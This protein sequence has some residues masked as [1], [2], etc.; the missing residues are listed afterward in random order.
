MRGLRPGKNT[1]AL[2]SLNNGNIQSNILGFFLLVLLC[3]I[4][5]RI[6]TISK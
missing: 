2:F 5:V 4:N 1:A 6:L 3:T